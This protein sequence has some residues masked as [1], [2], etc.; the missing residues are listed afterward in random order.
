MNDCFIIE[1]KR[2]TETTNGSGYK[3]AMRTKTL[4][5]RERF[6]E[7]QS[8]SQGFIGNFSGCILRIKKHIKLAFTYF[9]YTLNLT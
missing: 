4:S 6:S 3:V 8:F 1:K 7:S 5:T 9:L 2:G